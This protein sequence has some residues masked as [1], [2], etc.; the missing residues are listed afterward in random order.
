MRFRLRRSQAAAREPA[1]Q[2]SAPAGRPI[3]GPE[4]PPAYDR[5]PAEGRAYRAAP[6]EDP[7]YDR[8]PAEGRR[9]A[10][11]RRGRARE[12]G[13]ATVGAI[14]SLAIAAAGS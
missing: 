7:V 6:A 11:R 1:A 12:A 3:E 13:A 2:A 14:G 5:A 9:D 10:R 4:G 8:A